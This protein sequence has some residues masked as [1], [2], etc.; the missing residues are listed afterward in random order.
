MA[1]TERLARPFVVKTTDEAG[2]FEGLGAV[3]NDA[4]PTSSWRL[5]MDWTDRIS[6]GAFKRTLAAHAKAGTMPVMLYMHQRGN[7]VGAW[8]EMEEVKQG[9][10]V[11]GQVS[12]SARVENGAGLHE[13]MKMGAINALSIGFDVRVQKLDEKTKVRDIEEIELNELS[14][15]DIPGIHR[16]RVTDVKTGLIHIETLERVL[17]DAGLSRR[18]AKTLLAEGYAALRDAERGDEDNEDER[19]DQSGEALLEFNQWLRE[20]ARAHEKET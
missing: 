12:T 1:M 20:F 16:A 18:E 10:S 11:R 8:R 4:H 6:P 17:R 3:F 15:V 14:I 9:L 19:P 5:P 13:L 7:V 2:S